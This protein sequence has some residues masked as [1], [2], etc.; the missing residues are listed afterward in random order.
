MY[1]TRLVGGW[2]RVLR[3]LGGTPTAEVGK[4]STAVVMAVDCMSR[5]CVDRS[6]RVAFDLGGSLSCCLYTKGD[7]RL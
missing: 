3:D 6:L 1:A 2:S 5:T 4:A 7:A